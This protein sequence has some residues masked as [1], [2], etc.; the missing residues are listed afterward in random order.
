MSA[1][2]LRAIGHVLHHQDGC[3]FSLSGARC[4]DVLY[5]DHYS[6]STREGPSR[7]TYGTDEYGARPACFR[8]KPWGLIPNLCPSFWGLEVIKVTLGGLLWEVGNYNSVRPSLTTRKYTA[9][10]KG[11]RL[12]SQLTHW[13]R[14]LGG[15]RTKTIHETYIG[16]CLTGRT[17]VRPHIDLTSC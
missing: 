4:Y 12:G 1:S 6:T 7:P 14:L 16:S 2:T 5:Q 17:S 8:R 15:L 3:L 11:P 9:A 13:N 10:Q